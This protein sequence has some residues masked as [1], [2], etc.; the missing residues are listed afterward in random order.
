MQADRNRTWDPG[1]NKK[2][3]P[4]RHVCFLVSTAMI[5]EANDDEDMSTDNERSRTDLDSNANMVVVGRHVLI[6]SN[7]DRTAEVSPFTPDYDALQ[8]VPIV[9]AAILY[10]CPYTDHQHILIV[11]DALSVPSMIHN[12]IP[13]FV[14]REAG[15]RVNATPKIHTTHDPTIEDHSIY[16]PQNDFQIPLSLWGVFLYFPTSNPSL[17][18]LEECDKVFMLTPEG[19]WNPHSDVYTRNEENML[20]WEGNMVEKK[21]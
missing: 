12:L 16:F 20:D 3:Q 14:M 17:S 19:H 10:T 11:R 18:T 13:L 7:T 6:I 9:D 2:I 15:V 4:N 5:A 1:C 21:D 8:K